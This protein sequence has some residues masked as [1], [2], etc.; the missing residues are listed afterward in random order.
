MVADYLSVFNSSPGRLCVCA[1]CFVSRRPHRQQLND[2]FRKKND[3][4]HLC[5]CWW[6]DQG[7]S[8]GAI[9]KLSFCLNAISCI[10]ENS[11]GPR[12]NR[13]SGPEWKDTGDEG[14]SS[15]D[16]HTQT[17]ST[18]AHGG[19]ERIGTVWY[20]RLEDC[21]NDPRD[22]EGHSS[23]IVDCWHCSFLR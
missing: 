15:E 23:Y 12:V 16:C 1:V 17:C 13:L 5:K 21:V 4:L 10:R 20:H 8:N 18:H 19:P 3:V 22:E 6:W 9:I 11:R 2:P 7:D 14:H